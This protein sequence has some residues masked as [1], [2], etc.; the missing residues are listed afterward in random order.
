MLI[1]RLELK[2][3]NTV[4]KTDKR[5]RIVDLWCI[6][7]S[8]LIKNSQNK[9]KSPLS[10]IRMTVLPVSIEYTCHFFHI[11]RNSWRYIKKIFDD[12]VTICSIGCYPIVF[13]PLICE[14]SGVRSQHHEYLTYRW[15]TYFIIILNLMRTVKWRTIL[16]CISRSKP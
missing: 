5:F 1:R 13:T 7:C 6:C 4:F 2:M 16:V 9:N 14:Q 10:S 15:N 8:L 11:E 3:K 12:M